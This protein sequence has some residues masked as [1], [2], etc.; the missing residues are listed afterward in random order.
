MLAARVHQPVPVALEEQPA[1]AHWSSPTAASALAAP[2]VHPSSVSSIPTRRWRAFR[3]IAGIA[4]CGRRNS[5][6]VPYVRKS[7]NT[8][9]GALTFSGDPTAALHAVPRQYLDANFPRYQRVSLA[10][11][12]SFDVTVPAGASSAVNWRY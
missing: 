3:N 6:P 8:M 5:N 9:T 4:R 1:L 12:N 2:A 11:G 7:G 10:G